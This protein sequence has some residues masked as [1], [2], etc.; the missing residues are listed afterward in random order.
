MD[1]PDPLSSIR[2]LA[3]T[4]PDAC[5]GAGTVTDMTQVEAAAEAGASFL[6]SPVLDPKVIAAA[7]ASQIAMVPGALTPTEIEQAW[8][9]GSSAVKVFPAGALGAGYIASITAVLEAKVIATGGVGAGNARS[10]MDAGCAALGV[11]G[12]LT[13]G[14]VAEVEARARALMAAINDA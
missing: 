14:S 12:G 3:S 7:A 10:F 5:V 1:S 4:H 6:L 13:A 9:L 11:G 8:A 2:T